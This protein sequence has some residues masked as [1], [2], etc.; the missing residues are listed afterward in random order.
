LRRAVEFLTAAGIEYMLTGSLVSS[1]QGVPRLTHDIDI[2]VNLPPE[3]GVF[4]T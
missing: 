1:L 2:V 4:P 3:M